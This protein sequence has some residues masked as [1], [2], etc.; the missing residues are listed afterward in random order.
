MR[1]DEA[2]LGQ[3]GHGLAAQATGAPRAVAA[4]AVQVL[5][6]REALA[7]LGA[8]EPLALEVRHQQMLHDVCVFVLKRK[9]CKR[10]F[11]RPSPPFF[12]KSLSLFF[13]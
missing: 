11:T 13:F 7:A 5:L 4:H 2:V 8:L 10:K 9:E 12:Y 3:A 1:A 6:L